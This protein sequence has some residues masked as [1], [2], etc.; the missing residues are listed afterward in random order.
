MVEERHA[1]H[2]LFFFVLPSIV[3]PAPGRRKLFLA[4]SSLGK[5][6]EHLLNRAVVVAHIVLLGRPSVRVVRI[7][8]R[9]LIHAPRQA[10]ARFSSTDSKL[11]NYCAGTFPAPAYSPRHAPRPRQLRD[12]RPYAEPRY[13]GLFPRRAERLQLPHVIQR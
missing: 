11:P 6:R 4:P 9:M 5:P 12:W 2:A 13:E 7:N 8:I 1:Q 10:S 3:A